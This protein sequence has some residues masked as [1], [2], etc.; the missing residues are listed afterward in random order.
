[1]WQCAVTQVQQRWGARP[2]PT[3]TLGPVGTPLDHTIVGLFLSLTFSW[4]GLQTL[5][6]VS[7]NNSYANTAFPKPRYLET[8]HAAVFYGTQDLREARDHVSKHIFKPK[9]I[10]WLKKAIIR[11]IK[12]CYDC[13]QPQENRE[14]SYS[15]VTS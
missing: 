1:M 11:K 7:I 2:W 15:M 6:F 14:A 5:R 10:L 12:G 3:A 9:D 4:W 13:T 8:D